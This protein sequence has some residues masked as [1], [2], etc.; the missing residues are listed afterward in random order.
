MKTVLFSSLSLG[1][2]MIEGKDSLYLK[3]KPFPSEESDG[4][5]VSITDVWAVVWLR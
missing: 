5:E 1:K 3:D 2:W 4:V